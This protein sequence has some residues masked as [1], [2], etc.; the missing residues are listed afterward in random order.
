MQDPIITLTT[1]FGEDSPYVAA[2][3][4]VLLSINPG[5]RIVDLTHL[6]PP[7]DIWHA[8][9]FLTEAIPFFPAQALHVVVVDPGVGTSRAILY[10]EAGHHRLL[11]PDNGAITLLARKYGVRVARRITEAR[12]WRADVSATFHG[13]DI[14]APVAGYLGMGLDPAELGPSVNHWLELEIP[15]PTTEGDNLHG[16]ALFIDH[17]GNLLTNLPLARLPKQPLRLQLRGDSGGLPLER[18]VRVVRSYGEAATGEL[19]ALASSGGWWEFAIVNGSAAQELGVR[20]G[21]PIIARL[22]PKS[23]G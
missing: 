9:F 3:K 17:F 19:I 21:D 1:D 12:F 13:R 18:S 6:I 23:P 11:V 8:A 4:G 16:T 22:A 15:A 14:F 10:V 7:Q 2:M 5:A 20:R